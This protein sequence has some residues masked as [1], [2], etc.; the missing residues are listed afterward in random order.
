M[1]CVR[2]QRTDEKTFTNVKRMLY[3]VQFRMFFYK[4]LHYPSIIKTN[5]MCPSNLPQFIVL[6]VQ[7]VYLFLCLSILS[8][9]V[10][11]T[12]V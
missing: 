1:V 5:C 6:T 10:H 7:F 9:Y 12:N 4:P 8:F 11:T 3:F 2:E